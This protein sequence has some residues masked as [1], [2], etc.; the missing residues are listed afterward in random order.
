MLQAC[1]DIGGLHPEIS[2][3]HP[4]HVPLG[5]LDGGTIQKVL[6]QGFRPLSVCQVPLSGSCR[7]GRNI[8]LANRRPL[9]GE[10]L[11]P[12]RKILRGK[13]FFQ[14]FQNSVL[15]LRGL[16]VSIGHSNGHVCRRGTKKIA[17]GDRGIALQ[18]PGDPLPVLTDFVIALPKAGK[19]IRFIAFHGTGSAG[20]QGRFLY[21]SIKARQNHAFSDRS[22]VIGENLAIIRGKLPGAAGMF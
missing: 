9:A 11:V 16:C 14:P 1:A 6:D 4:S 13:P 22:P 20:Q 18:D 19:K 5:I 8:P 10:H 3:P 17:E 21:Q 7:K 2:F 12:I 15:L